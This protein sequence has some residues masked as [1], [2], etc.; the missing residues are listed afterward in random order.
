LQQ[1]FEANFVVCREKV[2]RMEQQQQ[3][4]AEQQPEAV[5]VSYWEELC[6]ECRATSSGS[7]TTEHGFEIRAKQGPS[8]HAAAV[9]SL[10]SARF[11][12]L[13]KKLHMTE[14][15][16]RRLQVRAEFLSTWHP[17]VMSP[18]C[19]DILLH[20]GGHIFRAHK[21]VL[22]NC[23]LHS[24]SPHSC[25]CLWMPFRVDNFLFAS[26]LLICKECDS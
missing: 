9:A 7:S 24:L 6:E 5:R 13:E 1:E 8:Y 22:V 17:V 21:S 11:K 4:E 16:E 14:E 3:E 12:L 20:A 26:G 23:S 25:P 15:R 10:A 18:G 19:T 2:R